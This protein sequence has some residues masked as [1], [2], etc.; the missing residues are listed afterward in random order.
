[1]W[2]RRP[3]PAPPDPDQPSPVDELEMLAVQLQEL[4]EQVCDTARRLQE[5]ERRGDFA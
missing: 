3:D 2:W 1:M 4:A 5:Q